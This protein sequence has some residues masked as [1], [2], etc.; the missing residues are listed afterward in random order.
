MCRK[1]AK[2]VQHKIPKSH[3]LTSLATSECTRVTHAQTCKYHWHAHTYFTRVVR[4]VAPIA[5]VTFSLS[6][7]T[8]S[9]QLFTSLSM[10]GG[11]H[12]TRSV[13]HVTFVAYPFV[14]STWGDFTIA[15]VQCEEGWGYEG[16]LSLDSETRE[17]SEINWCHPQAKRHRRLSHALCYSRLSCRRQA[18]LMLQ[19]TCLC[20]HVLMSSHSLY[21]IKWKVIHSSR[22][23]ASLVCT[24]K[25]HLLSHAS[26]ATDATYSL[27]L[28]L[29]HLIALNDANKCNVY[30]NHMCTITWHDVQTLSHTLTGD[31][32]VSLSPCPLG[33]SGE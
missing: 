4:N 11:V 22:L 2:C 23:F 9:C 17:T 20:A 24:G 5:A 1:S 14:N 31:H 15:S 3:S 6:L 10:S 8:S 21:S 27:H 29:L 16:N 18:Y 33:P 25:S 19:L 32:F 28:H 26:L 13:H 12:C 30:K 7:S